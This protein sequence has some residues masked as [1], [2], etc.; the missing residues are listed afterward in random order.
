MFSS[1]VSILPPFSPMMREKI[2]GGSW[3][4]AEDH[5]LFMTTTAL[6]YKR[7]P[8]L[9]IYNKKFDSDS[10]KCEEIIEK[11]PE[12]TL[13]FYW[14][15]NTKD[16]ET[17]LKK[18]HTSYPK[19]DKFLTE[20]LGQN[21]YIKQFEP[22]VVVIF[23]NRFNLQLYHAFQTFIP[24][25]FR[26]LFQ[27]NPLTER[28]QNLLLS[29]SK[30]TERNYK[31][32]I[33]SF[34]EDE[35]L[36]R[37]LLDEQVRGLEKNLRKAKYD[38]ALLEYN[39]YL[40]KLDELMEEYRKTC[41]KKNHAEVIACGLKCAMDAVDD[42]TEFEEYLCTNKLLSDIN[43]NGN[44]ISFVVKTFVDPYLP[45]DWDALSANGSI[46][47]D[48]IHTGSALDK[49]ENLKL[50]LDAIFSRNH[51]LKLRICGIICMDY[52]GTTVNSICGYNY[53]GQNPRLRD[54]VPNAH[55]HKHN[56]FG[57]NKNDILM[58]MR[59]GDMIGAVECCINVVK[60]INVAEGLS[61]GPFVDY[62]KSC[63]GKCIVTDDG[64]EMTC[65]EALTYLKEK[66]DETT[67][68]RV[69]E[70]DVA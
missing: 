35:D 39:D 8:E 68:D 49:E 12:N 64:Q 63:K 56:C 59:E 50:L 55:L 17:F 13:C 53:A 22:N 11:K 28:E 16:P 52:Y 3:F 19:H 48:H 38:R 31:E 10:E 7:W 36:K 70:T 62:I 60:R 29:V 37:F 41:D 51:C 54:Y 18:E 58:Q 1:Y 32:A 46:F 45:D 42:N 5:T 9:R 25:C 21:I 33:Q 57:Q 30:N 20:K 2:A 15:T 4:P 69:G 23:C 47:K 14:F 26:H 24:L 6:F 43:V 40:R 67:S 61:F 27:E 44:D 65:E 66:K 34:L